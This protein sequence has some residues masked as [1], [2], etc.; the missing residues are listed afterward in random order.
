MTEAGSPS[1]YEYSESGDRLRRSRGKRKDR[2]KRHPFVTFLI[3]LLSIVAF[4]LVLSLLIKSF[5]V[6]SFFIPSESMEDTLIVKDRIVVS[7]FYPTLLP[8]ERGDIVVFRD[9]GGWLGPVQTTPAPIWVQ[10]WDWFLASFGI[11]APDS[12]NHLVKRVIGLPGDHITCCDRDGHLKINGKSITEVYIKPG[13]SPSEKNFDITVPANSY[14][15]MGDNR[16]NSADS[17]FHMDLPSKG[18]VG[19]EFIVGRAI[20]LS[21]P[22]ERFKWLDNYPD[23]FASITK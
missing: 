17:R 10:A 1:E 16:S 7:E 6:R 15:V 14:W 12:E 13:A 5:I 3:D 2:K 21:W 22:F 4:A 18:F 19:R 8:L 9:P 23:V 20:V 11:T